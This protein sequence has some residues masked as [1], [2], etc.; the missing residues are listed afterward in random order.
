[1]SSLVQVGKDTVT[2]TE[3]DGA[4]DPTLPPDAFAC[5]WHPFSV[6][7]DAVPEQ[8]WLLT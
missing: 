7:W 1:M 5:W 6:T 8:S 2:G 3:L 4:S